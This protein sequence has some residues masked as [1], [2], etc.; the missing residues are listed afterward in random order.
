MTWVTSPPVP[1][2]TMSYTLSLTPANL[3][4]SAI[5]LVSKNSGKPFICGAYNYTISD[6][7]DFGIAALKSTELMIDLSGDI[8]L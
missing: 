7:P 1:S 3:T 5:D 8:S 4:V 2:S 6:T